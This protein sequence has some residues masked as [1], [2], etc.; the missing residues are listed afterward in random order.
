MFNKSYLLLGGLGSLVVLKQRELGQLKRLLKNPQHSE[1]TIG[2]STINKVKPF[3]QFG[4][5]AGESRCASS[6]TD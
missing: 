3:L 1:E 6:P 2:K 4:A 5:C